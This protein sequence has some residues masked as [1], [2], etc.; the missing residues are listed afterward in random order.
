MI[1]VLT[2]GLVVYE[3]L[4]LADVSRSTV[5]AAITA[6]DPASEAARFVKE[7]N[8][9]I[10]VRTTVDD[11]LGLVRVDLERK[12]RLPVLFMSRVLPYFSI[13]A[14]AVMMREPTATIGDGLGS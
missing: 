10:R 9:Q 13:R 6:E 5:R 7:V 2:A 8:S 1:F 4:A 11:E 14:S 12:R 3:H